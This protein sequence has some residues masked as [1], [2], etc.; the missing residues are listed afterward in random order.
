MAYSVLADTP[1][2]RAINWGHSEPNGYFKGPALVP[3]LQACLTGTDGALDPCWDPTRPREQTKYQQLVV[4]TCRQTG[5]NVG[6]GEEYLFPPS[7]YV[8]GL[9]MR[10]VGT[11]DGSYQEVAGEMRA[12]FAACSVQGYGTCSEG[13][14]AGVQGIAKAEAIGGLGQLAPAQAALR[15]LGVS[16]AGTIDNQ[17]VWRRLCQAPTMTQRQLQRCPAG[18]LA[19]REVGAISREFPGQIE[20]LWIKSHTYRDGLVH[21][22]HNNRDEVAGQVAATHPNIPAL[23]FA[24]WDWDIVI[25]DENDER[26]EGDPRRAIRARA[27]AMHW[28]TGDAAES[29]TL[30]TLEGMSEG[31][32]REL[33]KA[34]KSRGNQHG[35]KEWVTACG[36]RW[37]L[38]AEWSLEPE[39]RVCAAEGNDS[40]EAE[41][42][43]HVLCGQCSPMLRALYVNNHTT[44]VEAVAR[45][46]EPQDWA[47]LT[48][49]ARGLPVGQGGLEIQVT[50]TEQP[51]DEDFWVGTRR[52][53][54]GSRVPWSEWG[55][56]PFMREGPFGQEVC[57]ADIKAS[58]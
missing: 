32:Q 16:F 3:G 46:L 43:G 28:E 58:H 27:A 52:L 38:R 57:L 13:R 9:G 24:K 19:I 12:A 44:L 14:L 47:Q 34:L 40:P 7:P 37:Q 29:R 8:T 4:A 36:Q 25:F 49:T 23:R 48:W 42:I 39:C 41:T 10:L 51:L 18:N 35:Q 55:T 33:S 20:W 56:R 45:I 5:N 53:A 54:D 30:R 31:Q 21:D 11:S 1:R 2:P 26:V 22:R 6:R 50:S 15:E 17:G